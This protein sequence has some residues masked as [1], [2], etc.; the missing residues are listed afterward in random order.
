MFWP[1]N[2]KDWVDIL[3]KAVATVFAIAGGAWG[4]YQYFK[5]TQLKA[6]ESLL[7]AEEEF[8]KVLPTF[9]EIEDLPTY[10]TNI[11]PVL[12]AR[13]EG[14]L[15]TKSLSKLTEIDRALRFLFLCSV[16]NETLRADRVFGAKEGAL[17]KAYYYYYGIM[18]DVEK[19]RR[20]EFDLYTKRYYP[21]LTEWVRKHE[22]DLLAVRDPSVE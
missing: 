16:L 6:A 22:S 19:A 21:R 7:K 14:R 3:T 15:D 13:R 5:G 1:D 11:K 18:L 8:R 4:L 12:D 2:L 17:H 10:R 20:P 9:E